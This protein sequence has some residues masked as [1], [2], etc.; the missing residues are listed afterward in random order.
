MQ[1][2][3]KFKTNTE[4]FYFRTL[5]KQLFSFILTLKVYSFRKNN[6]LADTK[7]KKQWIKFIVE[8]IFP[9]I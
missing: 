9:Q 2:K 7:E 6:T 5:K 3:K 8:I 1:R 4:K